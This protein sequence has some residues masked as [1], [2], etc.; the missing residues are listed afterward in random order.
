MVSLAQGAARTVVEA[1]FAMADPLPRPLRAQILYRQ[2]DEALW[3][4]NLDGQ[5][6]RKLK[7]RRRPQCLRQL[8]R[9]RK[10]AALPESAR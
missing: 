1:P 6:N 2:G 4:V 5:Q 8:D 7:T 3:M 10:N 9:G